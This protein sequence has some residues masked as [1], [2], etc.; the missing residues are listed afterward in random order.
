MF[1]D[2]V[3]TSVRNQ[4][5]AGETMV[6]ANPI[7]G[8]RSFPVTNNVTFRVNVA[9]TIYVR[10]GWH[11]PSTAPSRRVIQADGSGWAET[12][13]I[14]KDRYLWAHA[15]V[16]GQDVVVPQGTNSHG[17]GVG[18]LPYVRFYF[19]E[20]TSTTTTTTA[21]PASSLVQVED[22]IQMEKGNQ[23]ENAAPIKC[24]RQEAGKVPLTSSG[25]FVRRAAFSTQ[26][27]AT[28]GGCGQWC[29]Q[30]PN[31]VAYGTFT[32]V[33]R[34]CW[35]YSS[36]LNAPMYADASAKYPGDG[37]PIASFTHEE[38]NFQAY[39]CE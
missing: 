27:I 33:G 2:G 9:G 37:F 23:S 10:G 3:P 38:P 18:R 8:F 34:E 16:P 7:G 36:S 39:T 14:D 15:A 6:E 20:G 5:L 28:K 22:A 30:D 26:T 13:L 35:C 29:Q 24:G 17:N 31:L 25:G 4:E 21:E 12:G 1:Q 11:D 32:Q 19:R